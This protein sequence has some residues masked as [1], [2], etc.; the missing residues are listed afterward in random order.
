MHEPVHIQFLVHA[1]RLCYVC[2][3]VCVYVCMFV[4]VHVSV[5]LVSSNLLVQQEA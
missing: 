2:V 1:I 5:V 4:Y 3:C